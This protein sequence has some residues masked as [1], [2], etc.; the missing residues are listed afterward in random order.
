[1]SVS[2]MPPITMSA[3]Y[4]LLTKA[5]PRSISHTSTNYNICRLLDYDDS[6]SPADLDGLEI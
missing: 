2:H 1:M 4:Q 3:A 5:S 6:P